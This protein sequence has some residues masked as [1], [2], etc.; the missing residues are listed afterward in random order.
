MF[1]MLDAVRRMARSFGVIALIHVL[2][3]VQPEKNVLIGKPPGEN[4]VEYL[5]LGEGFNL[6]SFVMAPI[7]VEWFLAIGAVVFV[8]VLLVR[9]NWNIIIRWL[10]FI[11]VLFLVLAIFKFIPD[12]LLQPLPPGVSGSIVW[13]GQIDAVAPISL[14]WIFIGAF[15]L[16][17][18]GCLLYTSPSPRDA[19]LSRMPSSA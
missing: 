11:A 14:Y 4:P 9:S 19:T 6:R 7:G 16:K 13:M 1:G 18:I 17:I 8:M 3:A 10:L 2:I 12:H 5:F 15:G